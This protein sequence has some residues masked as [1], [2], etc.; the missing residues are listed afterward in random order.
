MVRL[1]TIECC[2]GSIPVKL[3]ISVTHNF[4]FNVHDDSHGHTLLSFI[5]NK[6]RAILHEE[7]KISRNQIYKIIDFILDCILLVQM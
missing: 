3:K 5:E 4:G 7:L 2:P 1:Q 6:H